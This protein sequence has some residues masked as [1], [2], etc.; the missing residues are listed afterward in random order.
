MGGQ[1]IEVALD[2]LLAHL[3][4]VLLVI[5]EDELTYPVNIGLFSSVNEMFLLTGDSHLIK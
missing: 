1:V 2:F 4:G 3:A 5:E